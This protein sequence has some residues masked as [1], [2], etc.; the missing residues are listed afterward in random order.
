VLI[1]GEHYPPVIAAA[2][3]NL[4]SGGYDPVAAVFLGGTEKVGH[5]LDLGIPIEYGDAEEEL[6]EAMRRHRPAVVL[7]LSDE[8][9]VGHR[10]RFRLAGIALQAGIGY[11]GAG[12]RFDPPPR[13]VLTDTPTVEITATGKRTGKTALSIELAR[14]WHSAGRRVCIVTMGR[15]GPPEPVVLRSGEFDGS[16]DGL[17]RLVQRGLHAASDYAEDALFAGVDTVGTFRCGAGFSGQTAYDNFHLGVSAAVGLNPEI[18]ILEGS[19]AA[20]PPAKADASL[21][22]VPGHVEPEYLRGY[23]GPYRLALADAAIV[24]AG[25]GSPDGARQVVAEVAPQL[26]TFVGSYEV[27]PTVPV[28]GRSVLVVSTAPPDASAGLGRSLFANGALHV[29]T[30]HSLSD[31][32]TLAADLAPATGHD[33]VLVEVKAAAIDTVLPWATSRGL[34]VGL[35]HNRVRV[36]GGIEDLAAVVEARWLEAQSR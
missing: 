19:G 6:L 26:A 8:P 10:R 13:P 14:H 34:E 16:P 24:I 31:R 27:E 7:D 20:I 4:R 36:A 9:V 35:V 1:D 22:V 18:L 5:P 21:L 12:F 15:G 28:A 17:I 29:D 32:T 33:L 11:A 25:T 23:F 30:V 3:S 2:V